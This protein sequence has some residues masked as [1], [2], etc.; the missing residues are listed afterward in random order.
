M[1]SDQELIKLALAVCTD[2]EQR[3]YLATGIL[4]R[5]LARLA[6]TAPASA[7]PAKPG[8]CPV[9]GG[10]LVGRRQTCSD[11]CRQRLSRHGNMSQFE[12]M[13][14]GSQPNPPSYPEGDRGP[15]R[16]VVSQPPRGVTRT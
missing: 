16:R 13:W 12:I 5:C 3:G 14:H 4:R 15:A 10:P 9:C 6:A 1:S 2:L 8:A 11:R 7:K